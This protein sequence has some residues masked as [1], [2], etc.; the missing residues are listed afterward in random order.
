[1]LEEGERWRCSCRDCGTYL[2]LFEE[3][4]E[5]KTLHNHDDAKDKIELLDFNKKIK[6]QA[7]ATTEKADKI[8]VRETRTINNDEVGNLRKPKSIE[9][10]IS[11][12]S[13]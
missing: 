8:I 13:K 6:F 11:R 7:I 12:E 9:R 1:M 3:K 10:I 5:I 4:V 2:I